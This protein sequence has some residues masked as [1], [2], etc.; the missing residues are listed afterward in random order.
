MAL[1]FPLVGKQESLLEAQEPTRQ[2]TGILSKVNC[3][4]LHPMSRFHSF[5]ITPLHENL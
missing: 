4:S 2:I 5:S 1:S 3:G